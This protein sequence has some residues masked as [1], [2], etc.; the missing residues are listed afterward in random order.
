MVSRSLRRLCDVAAPS[1][2]WRWQNTSIQTMQC[3]FLLRLRALLC[4]CLLGVMGSAAA[5]DY[6][7][8]IDAP[9]TLKILLEKNLDIVRWRGN[10]RIDA[11]QL[12]RLV[13]AAPEQ[14]K[15]LVA[16]EG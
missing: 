12:Q 10:A 4:L 3:C 6:E 15:T 7:V 1:V 16:T 11:E 9:D 5:A 14:I 2:L 13:Q 8:R